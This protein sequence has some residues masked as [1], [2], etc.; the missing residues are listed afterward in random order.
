M[1]KDK[2]G[3]VMGAA[4]KRSIAWAIAKNL[5]RAGA[6]IA[7]SYQGERLGRNVKKLAE[8]VDQSITFPCDVTKDEEIHKFFERVGKEF[9]SIDFLV[10]SIAFAKKE[11]LDG[12]FVNI[13][14]EGYRTANDI[15]SFSL[16]AAS[17]AA[18]DLMSGSGGSIVTLSY[19][20]AERVIPKY[21]VMGVAKAALES[22]VKY[23]AWNLG[24]KNIR[25]NAVSAGPINTLAA[26]GI[27]GFSEM[28]H[29]VREKSPLKRN[30]EPDEV[31]DTVLFLCSNMA[32]G[33]T[34]EVIYV[35]SGY[36]IMG[37]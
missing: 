34:G 22:S 33:I 32:R 37:M 29:F 3:V 2:K 10:H 11:D 15:S 27:P 1:L 12:E 25:V 14:R 31:A 19:L 28:L 18:L 36:H 5:A 16:V 26:R 30:T 24:S 9:G 21:N 8:E 13:S 35:D 7:L 17:K 4:N 20:G 6:S 23:L